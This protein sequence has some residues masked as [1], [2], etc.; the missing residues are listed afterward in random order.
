MGLVEIFRKKFSLKIG[1][2]LK[3]SDFGMLR[4]LPLAVATRSEPAGNQKH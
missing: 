1:I 3:N 4:A 2:L